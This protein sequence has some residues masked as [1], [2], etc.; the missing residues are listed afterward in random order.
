MV[1]G[2]VTSSP[3]NKTDDDVIVI[4]DNNKVYVLV[5]WSFCVTLMIQEE[6][7]QLVNS[8]EEDGLD[9]KVCVS[10]DI[11]CSTDKLLAISHGGALCV[12]SGFNLY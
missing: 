4:S 10:S 5:I 11:E 6:E 8:D 12:H 2:S 9:E 3:Y 7:V 1:L